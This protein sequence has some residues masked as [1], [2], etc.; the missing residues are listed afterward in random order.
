MLNTT[1]AIKSIKNI[2]IL[3]YKINDKIC[4]INNIILN[5]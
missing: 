3:K 5:N 1:R 2:T 4:K